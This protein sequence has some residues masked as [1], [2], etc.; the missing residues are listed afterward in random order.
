MSSYNLLRGWEDYNQRW[1]AIRSQYHY[2]TVL[3]YSSVFRNFWDTVSLLVLILKTWF[4]D[5]N[6][7]TDCLY[8]KFFIKITQ[9]KRNTSSPPWDVLK[10]HW[11]RSFLLYC[12]LHLLSECARKKHSSG[13]FMSRVLDES[14]GENR[15]CVSRDRLQSDSIRVRK[16]SHTNLVATRHLLK[17]R[18]KAHFGLT[19][20]AQKQSH[21][22]FILK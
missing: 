19:C 6:F 2:G 8:C 10:E 5:L 9:L 14:Q 3:T 1:S 17:K 4:P 16:L 15:W 12:W 20:V 21:Y 7:A 22:Y 13:V 18:I 11:G